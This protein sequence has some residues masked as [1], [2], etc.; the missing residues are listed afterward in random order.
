MARTFAGKRIAP[1]LLSPESQEVLADKLYAL[2]ARIFD[3]LERA[4]FSAYLMKRPACR[5]RIQVYENEQ[6]EWVGYVAVQSFLKDL[7]GKPV[8]VLRTVVGML[9]DHQQ[10]GVPA[11][12]LAQETLR[13]MVLYPQRAL[14]LVCG[15]INPASYLSLT[16]CVTTVLPSPAREL[17]STE[18]ALLDALRESCQLKRVSET[19]PYCVK[20]GWVSKS[21]VGQR[22]SWEQS[23]KPAV[24]FFLR[25]NPSYEE[26]TGML[27][28]VPISTSTFVTGL[29]RWAFGRVK[30]MFGGRAQLPSASSH[31]PPLGELAMQR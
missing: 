4:A 29:A 25:E 31:L 7:E 21:Q 28:A 18:A 6:G 30:R 17:S 16:R 9:P 10:Q 3:G 2:H 27:V 24:Q 8:V 11:G 5:T 15:L 1:E 26:G 12:L 23:P 22:A 19:L 13:N 20:I 14:Y